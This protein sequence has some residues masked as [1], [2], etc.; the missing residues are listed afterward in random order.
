MS[1]GIRINKYLAER[2]LCSRREADR[3]VEDRRVEI[4]GRAAGPGDRVRDGDVVRVD[5]RE[6]A[7]EAGRRVV[8]AYHKPRG[9]ECTEDR[10]NPEAFVHHVRTNERVFSV[11]RLDKYS[12]GLLL[13]TNRGEI[14]KDLLK[15]A[16]GIEK[17]YQ[18]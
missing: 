11:G 17:D 14:V 5:G 8:Y 1:D 13:L 2:G 16:R 10:D 6:I 9:I 18:V 3:W 7:T 12:E 15:G 4:N